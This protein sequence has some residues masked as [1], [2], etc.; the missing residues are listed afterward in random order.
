M[1]IHV[2]NLATLLLATSWRTA[3]LSWAAHCMVSQMR[4]WGASSARIGRSPGVCGASGSLYS[5][6]VRAMV[7]RG[8]S[9]LKF[10][11]ISCAHRS[12]LGPRRYEGQSHKGAML[13]A[14][15]GAVG[16]RRAGQ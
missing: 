11:A 6:S 13:L 7:M 5:F 8:C 1:L 12:D 4:A 14:K 2:Q 9:R 3:L 16:E 15:S 10:T